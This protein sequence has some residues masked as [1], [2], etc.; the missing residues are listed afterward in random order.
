MLAEVVKEDIKY[1]NQ[2]IHYC[3]VSC[4][5]AKMRL[6]CWFSKRRKEKNRLTK[7]DMECTHIISDDDNYTKYIKR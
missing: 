6:T 3:S 4:T 2:D 7:N 5:L 1:R